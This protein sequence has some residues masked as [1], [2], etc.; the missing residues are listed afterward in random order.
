LSGAKQSQLVAQFQSDKASIREAWQT[1]GDLP[2]L[3]DRAH[4]RL[5]Q[6][7]QNWRHLVFR[8]YRLFGVPLL[9]FVLGIAGV[10]AWNRVYDFVQPQGAEQRTSLISTIAQTAGGFILV[11]GLFFTAKTYLTNREGQITERFT[12]A[13]DQLSSKEFSTRLGGIYGLERIAHDSSRDQKQVI[14]VLTAFVR[15]AAPVSSSR[16]EAW[17]EIALGDAEPRYTFLE[18]KW[19]GKKIQPDVQAVITVLGRRE[20][21]PDRQEPIE[22]DLNK[23]DLRGASWEGAYLPN[24]ALINCDLEGA[25]MKFCDL[26][27]AYLSS[28]NIRNVTFAGACLRESWI[29]HAVVIGSHFTE[30]DFEGANVV[31]TVFAYSMFS[32]AKMRRVGFHRCNLDYAHFWGTDLTLADFTS[33]TLNGTDFR[34]AILTHANFRGVNL[35]NCEGLTQQQINS[36]QTDQKTIPPA[37]LTITSPH[38]STAT[39][40]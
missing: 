10:V 30:V 6:S 21:G 40:P 33:A 39:Q 15:E 38:P 22:L 26:T 17:T 32:E 9:S 13:I 3:L 12:R 29:Q 4:H 35:S 37:G 16:L 19:D 14:E 7:G 34:D 24:A 28:S 18:W 20:H 2:Q 11:L 5:E 25:W 23:T 8:R 36:A 27:G 1:R 31:G